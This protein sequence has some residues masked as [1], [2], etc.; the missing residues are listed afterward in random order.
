ML[1]GEV[2]FIY[3]SRGDVF[4]VNAHVLVDVHVALKEKILEIP[5]AVTSTKVSIG[6]DAVKVDLGIQETDGRQANILV[7]IEEIATDSDSNAPRFGFSGSHRADELRIGHFPVRR[8][9]A[10]SCSAWA[11]SS[12]CSPD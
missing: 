4:T 11:D 10:A 2:I 8:D 5:S 12:G 1:V 3:H 9:L 6:D 7:G